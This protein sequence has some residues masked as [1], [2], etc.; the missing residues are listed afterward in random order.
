LL[1]SWRIHAL[2]PPLC[3]NRLFIAPRFLRTL[4]SSALQLFRWY[5]RWL[6]S[7][8]VWQHASRD[9]RRHWGTELHQHTTGRIPGGKRFER[10]SLGR[11]FHRA[12]GRS[13]EPIGILAQLR[14]VRRHFD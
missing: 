6:G 5:E 14:L 4:T 8:R 13:P 3:R 11:P 12:G 2:P 1:L 10:Q 7:V 9:G